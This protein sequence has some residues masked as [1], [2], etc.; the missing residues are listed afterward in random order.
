MTLEVQ[1][2]VIFGSSMCLLGHAGYHR[3]LMSQQWKVKQMK[4]GQGCI[5]TGWSPCTSGDRRGSPTGHGGEQGGNWSTKSKCTL[6]REVSHPTSLTNHLSFSS[7]GSRAPQSTGPLWP[8]LEQSPT[9]V[10][11]L[12][13]LKGL[14]SL[15]VS[16]LP[17]QLGCCHCARP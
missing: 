6:L 12:Q 16:W 5:V 8:W 10:R 17:F 13:G 14:I 11:T 4:T 2:P 15:S 9:K 1:M 3:P 7:G